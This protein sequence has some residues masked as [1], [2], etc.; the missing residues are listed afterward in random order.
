MLQ[1]I[2]YFV[3]LHSYIDKRGITNVKLLNNK[4]THFFQNRKDFN[5]NTELF[6]IRHGETEWNKSGRYQGCTDIPLS[7]KGILQAG[8]LRDRFQNQFDC[9]YTSPLSRALETAKIIGQGSNIEPIIS[10]PFIEINFG[11]WEGLNINEIK[12]QYPDEFHHWRTDET[13]ANLMSSEGSIKA[14]SM[15]AKNEALRLVQTHPGQRILVIGHG[16]IIKAA[17]IGLMDWKMTMYHKFMF[18]NTSVTKL[19][20]DENLNSII[21]TINDTSH[22]Y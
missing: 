9:L 7:E 18:G 13:I 10:Y 4:L 17:L 15:R 16:G 21:N 11:I 1:I 20:F 12:A 14:A 22:L 19:T 2:Y 5:M 3:T 8:L 6:L